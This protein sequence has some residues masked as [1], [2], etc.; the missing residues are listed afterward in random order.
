MGTKKKKRRASYVEP[1]YREIGARIA[2]IRVFFKLTQTELGALCTPKLSRQHVANIEN[3]NQRL[4]LHT[5]LEIAAAL[6]V[7]PSEILPSII[8]LPE[9]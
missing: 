6:Q 3:A 2:E 8:R 7:R 4:Q 9:K 1:V 5:A